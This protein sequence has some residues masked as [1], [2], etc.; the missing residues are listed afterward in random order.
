MYTKELLEKYASGE[1]DFYDANLRGAD[2]DFSSWP[3]WCGSTKV[4]TDARQSKQLV[5]HALKASKIELRSAGGW[6]KLPAEFIAWANEFHHA[7]EC[8]KLTP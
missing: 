4:F 3:L 5:Y 2:L 8:G 6:E 7:E 1:R